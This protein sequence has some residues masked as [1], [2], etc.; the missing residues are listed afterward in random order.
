MKILIL[1]YHLLPGGVTNVIIDQVKSLLT[2]ASVE[3]ITLIS[4]QSDNIDNVNKCF[5]KSDKVSIEVLPSVGYRN[6][7]SNEELISSK[8][9]LALSL[10]P[11]V[12]Q[13]DLIWIHNYHLGKNIPLT[14]YWLDIIQQTKD[15]KFLLHIHDFPESGRFDNLSLL[16]KHLNKPLY[17]LNNHVKYA[18]INYR[19][20][21]YLRKNGINE[22]QVFFLPNPIKEEIIP[23]LDPK[24][25]HDM[26][27]YLST[28]YKGIKK[29]CPFRLYPVRS[30]RRKNI[31]EALFWSILQPEY[32]IIITLPGVSNREK[33]YSQK[34]ESFLKEYPIPSAT[35][36][37]LI[38]SQKGYSF[39]NIVSASHSVISTSV[40]E[41]FGYLFLNS[42]IWNKP[43]L[44]RQLPILKGFDKYFDWQMS[45]FYTE[46]LVPINK[47]DLVR[48]KTAYL[49]KLKSLKAYIN[50][51]VMESLSIKIQTIG[52][53]GWID[54]SFLSL[55]DQLNIIK[56]THQDE[57]L[58]E[59][60]ID[61]NRLS[62]DRWETN[63][64]NKDITNNILKDFGSQAVVDK[65]N[66]LTASF[67]DRSHKKVKTRDISSDLVDKFTDL[68]TIRLLYD[69][70]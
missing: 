32:N 57:K 8:Q 22:D 21:D 36:A 31:G 1:H 56:T 46:L 39:T 63:N 66:Q 19:D 20:Y 64:V 51:Q 69:Y 54:F 14:A 45:T 38:L 61:R 50:T 10:T 37:G 55:N 70:K 52:K 16:R 26:M 15:K 11:F 18:L 41:G 25:S 40:Q 35:S 53:E 68:D 23:P 13:H 3:H 4:G 60:I 58:R 33:N 12:R 27:S 28:F 44:A 24:T 9:E 47:E 2:L 67:T 65:F 5:P 6:V 17:P 43:L 34:I 62:M 30:I 7:S 48:L 42:Q 49:N 29:D 59:S